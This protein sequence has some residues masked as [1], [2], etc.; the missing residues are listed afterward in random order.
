MPSPPGTQRDAETTTW[1][2][3]LG[4]SQRTADR[5]QGLQGRDEGRGATRGPRGRRER[6]LGGACC[7]Q[8]V[9]LTWGDRSTPSPQQRGAQPGPPSSPPAHPH[10]HSGAAQ[11]VPVEAGAPRAT[12]S[13]ASAGSQPSGRWMLQTPPPP[14][15]PQNPAP[16][17]PRPVGEPSLW[18][19]S[20][21]GA[22]ERPSWAK[23]GDERPRVSG[24]V[25]WLMEIVGEAA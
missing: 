11:H 2:S 1:A 12:R 6:D 14:L 21:A 3:S 5:L 15:A 9:W 18:A 4:T 22:G 16:P 20:S 25:P 7:T 17:R 8:G 23:D 19:T 13:S 24:T 10:A